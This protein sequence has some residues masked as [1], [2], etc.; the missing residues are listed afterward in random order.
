VEHPLRR[1]PNVLLTPHEAAGT[2][3]SRRRA[4]D[5]VV[6]EIDRFLRGEPLRHEVRPEDLDRTG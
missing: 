5:I 4:A 6:A 3:G 1:L 2:V